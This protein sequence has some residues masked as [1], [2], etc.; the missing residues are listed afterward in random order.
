M[1]QENEAYVLQF[2]WV[3]TSHSFKRQY[4]SGCKEFKTI[5]NTVGIYEGLLLG[6]LQILILADI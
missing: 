2:I 5:L 6:P 3:P 4:L 1:V